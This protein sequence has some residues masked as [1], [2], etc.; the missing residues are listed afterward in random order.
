MSNIIKGIL[1]GMGV[2]IPGVSGSVLAILLGVYEN[3][4][5]IFNNFDLDIKN[6]ISYLLKLIIGIL[7]GMS[8]FGNIILFLMPKYN[9]LISFIF[10]G[11]ILGSIPGLINE[12]KVKNKKFSFKLFF[13]SLTISFL[14]FFLG[15]IETLQITNHSGSLKSIILLILGGFLFISG[16]IIPGISSSFFM[17]IL[18]LY[19]YVLNFM[20]NP[21]SISVYGYIEFI[22]FI[23][24]CI[25]GIIILTKFINFCLITKFE[26]T[27]SCIIGFV[28][29]SIFSIIPEVQFTFNYFTSIIICIFMFF[30]MKNM[31]KVKK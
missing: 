13:L 14:L 1:I 5:F 2:V 28:A 17:M 24:G 15:N 21:F 18:G 9:I 10:V 6:N 23:I 19:N 3:I 7:I 4:L 16:K 12:I 29:G 11:L 30:A 25:L 20:S 26:Q 8:I 31:S 27:Y 22:P